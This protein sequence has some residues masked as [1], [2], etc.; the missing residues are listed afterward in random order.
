MKFRFSIDVKSALKTNKGKKSNLKFNSSL[1][2]LSLIPIWN[3]DIIYKKEIQ[4]LNRKSLKDS[5]QIL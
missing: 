1:T 2:A 3:T 5:S 4:N